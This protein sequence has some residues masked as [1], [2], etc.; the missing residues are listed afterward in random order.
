MDMARDR[1]RPASASWASEPAPRWKSFA[2]II[3]SILLKASLFDKLTYLA[4]LLTL[5]CGTATRVPTSSHW[6][7]AQLSK[8]LNVENQIVRKLFRLQ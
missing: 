1:W 6:K 5:R 3:T 8:P 2:V 7:G 4:R